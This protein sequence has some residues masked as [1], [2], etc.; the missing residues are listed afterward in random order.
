MLELY[1]LY[2]YN[3]LLSQFESIAVNINANILHHKWNR[4]NLC[5]WKNSRWNCE[6]QDELSGEIF[7]SYSLFSLGTGKAEEGVYE[8]QTPDCNLKSTD[9][10]FHLLHFSW[11]KASKLVIGQP[12]KSMN[13]C[14]ELEK[15]GV[16]KA[17]V[18]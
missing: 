13:I 3:H 12:F 8:T 11:K 15:Y 1:F 17:L 2:V 5:T 18:N 9:F 6:H 10:S 7:L 14:K 4:E 16:T